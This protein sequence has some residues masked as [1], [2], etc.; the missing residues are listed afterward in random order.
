MNRGALQWA[1]NYF[2]YN[3]PKTFPVPSP[4]H[5]FMALNRS[6]GPTPTGILRKARIRV[7]CTGT[8]SSKKLGFLLWYSWY[9]LFTHAWPRTWSKVIKFFLSHVSSP[10]RKPPDLTKS[11]TF[12]EKYFRVNARKEKE[13][14]SSSETTFIG[15]EL[16]VSTSLLRLH[17]VTIV[18]MWYPIFFESCHVTFK[19]TLWFL[20]NK[21]GIATL[22]RTSVVLWIQ[23]EEDTN[24]TDFYGNMDSDEDDMMYDDDAEDSSNESVSGEGSDFDIDCGDPSTPKRPHMSDD[25]HYECLTPEPLVAYMNE[26]I[27]EVNSVFQVSA[28]IRRRI[29]EFLAWI[30]NN[31]GSQP[32]NRT[33]FRLSRGFVV[34]ERM[35]CGGFVWKL[36]SKRSVALKKCFTNRYTVGMWIFPGGCSISLVRSYRSGR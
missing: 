9:H 23:R 20:H 25:F 12:G 14:T 16:P 2:S 32:L 1:N 33:L 29:R 26:V 28:R 24:C 8:A 5:P 17:D 31:F 6:P 34:A 15:E 3:A 19:K 10:F 35:L 13:C 18:S 4:T 27:D 21:D 11:Y 22:K 7:L 36:R 30:A